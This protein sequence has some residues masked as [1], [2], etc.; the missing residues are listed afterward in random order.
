MI[1]QLPTGKVVYVSLETYL[2]LTDEDI[3][4][5]ISTGGGDSPNN[6]FHGTAMKQP[7]TSS[8]REVHDE[9][10]DYQ[11][12]ADDQIGSQEQINLDGLADQ[13]D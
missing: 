2:S 11:D 5:L 4:Y 1:F 9:S 10:I 13:E 6:P 3:Q 7:R 8:Y 12:E